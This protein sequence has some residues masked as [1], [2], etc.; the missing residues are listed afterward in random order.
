MV[1]PLAPLDTYTF[2]NVDA[3]HTIEAQFELDE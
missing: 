3:D 1:S 2:P